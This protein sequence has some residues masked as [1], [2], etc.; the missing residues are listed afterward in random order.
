M[1]AGGLLLLGAALAARVTD[2]ATSTRNYGTNQITVV[3]V[4]GTPVRVRTV[5]VV[6][7]AT[8]SGTTSQA[9]IQFQAGRD[10]LSRW[11]AATVSNGGSRKDIAI[12]SLDY[13]GNVQAIENLKNVSI[14]EIDFP[15]LDAI[16]KSAAIWGV[17]TT[18]GSSTRA[19]GS[20]TVSSST[21]KSLYEN[22][23][24]LQIDGFDPSA[25]IK[26]DPIVAR[27]T[28]LRTDPRLAIGTVRTGETTTGGTSSTAFSNLV[29]YVATSK[30]APYQQWLSS[31]HAPR[32]GVLTFLE[33]DMKTAYCTAKLSGLVVTK[34]TTDS[35]TTRSR[36]EMTLP[37]MS[38]SCG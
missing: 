11:M 29:V 28:L 20:G 18:A 37:A 19:A 23:F 5:D 4:D 15:A 9:T 22:G 30:A 3:S 31:G 34:I 26:I 36:I 25:V 13:S 12:E 35:T 1:A 21:A 27:S 7:T 8:A 6:D 2:A 10:T 16:G 38:L 32:N 24:R 33:P 17:K 14:Q